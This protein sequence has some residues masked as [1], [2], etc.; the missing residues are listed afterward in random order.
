MKPSLACGL[1]ALIVTANCVSCLSDDF[2]SSALESLFADFEK[3]EQLHK[4]VKRELEQND[5]AEKS[6]Q[7]S[8]G[9]IPPLGK[10][11]NHLNS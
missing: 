1:L 2:L 3:D 4:L 5:D 9:Y 8:E 6:D 7:T 11:R 10:F